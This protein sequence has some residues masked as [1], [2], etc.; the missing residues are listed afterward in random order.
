MMFDWTWIPMALAGYAA[1]MMTWHIVQDLRM[2][3]DNPPRC[4]RCG[5]YQLN[6]GNC[7][8]QT[9][10]RLDSFVDGMANKRLTYTDLIAK[11]EGN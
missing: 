5:C 10:N 11:P 8:R 9:L 1:G 4:P 7:K 2:P 6:E 3:D